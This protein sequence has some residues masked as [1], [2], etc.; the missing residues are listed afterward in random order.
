MATRMRLW[1]SVSALIFAVLL[2]GLGWYAAVATPSGTG[3]AAKQ[4]CSLVFVSNMPAERAMEI[5]V[6][7]LVGPLPPFLNWQV[8]PA[9]KQTRV[10]A[11]GLAEARAVA[12]PGYGCIQLIDRN[13]DQV[14]ELL[15]ARP[16]RPHEPVALIEGPPELADA[17]GAALQVPHTL[18]VL[19]AKDGAVIAE[20]YAEGVGPNTPLPGWSMT[21]SLTVT[22]AGMLSQNQQLQTDETSLFPQWQNDPRSAISLDQLLRMTSGI[23]IP[24]TKTGADANSTMIFQAGDSLAYAIERGLLETPGT[25]FDYTSGSTVLAAGVIQARLGG[26]AAT[27]AF[28]NDALFAPL[29]M[30][31]TIIEPDEAGTFIGSSFV[32]ATARDWVKLGQLYLQGGEWQGAQLFDPSWVSYVTQHTPQSEARPYGAGFWLARP[33]DGDAPRGEWPEDTFYASGLQNNRLFIVPSR[34]LLVV[35]LGATTRY[36]ESGM[37]ELMRA[38]LAHD[39]GGCSSSSPT[40]S[41][42]S[43][44]TLQ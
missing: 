36:S 3:L 29:S 8:D 19:V 40:D 35:R 12:H 22:L 17:L 32:M 20:A 16:T 11:L 7:P 5:Y 31:H 28:I 25:V 38:V 1:R 9:L 18:A 27:Y 23:D 39:A 13:I 10:S 34:G 30:H 15:P 42:L 41:P 43:C 21:K 14:A 37:T 44:T 24:E 26:P 33:A 6:H 2:T 4:L